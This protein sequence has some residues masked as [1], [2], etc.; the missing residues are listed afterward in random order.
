VQS[1]FHD[2]TLAHAAAKAGY[3]GALLPNQDYAMVVDGNVG[4]TK[5]DYYVKKSID[6]KTEVY[7]QGLVRHLV[8]LRYNLPQPADATDQALNPGSGA[9]LDYIRVYLPKTSGVADLRLI[10]D[11]KLVGS[12]IDNITVEHGRQVVGTLL[13]LP[14]G[15]QAEIQLAYEVPTSTSGSYHL[16][17]QKQAGIPGTP[18]TLEFSYPGG[19]ASRA[20]VLDHDQS[21]DFQW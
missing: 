16:Y 14:R 10:M 4:A 21:F 7:P 15:H 2:A 1:F 18:L 20:T 17:L 6:I 3:D 19:Q 9:Y 11:G 12:S 5:G 8:S 13:R